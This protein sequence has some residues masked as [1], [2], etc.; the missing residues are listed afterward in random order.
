MKS[1]VPVKNR[2]FQNT[3][4]ILW[5][6]DKNEAFERACQRGRDTC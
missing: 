3:A 5:S 6:I 1:E 2:K 4:E